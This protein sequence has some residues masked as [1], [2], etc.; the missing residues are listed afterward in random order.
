[1]DINILMDIISH[2]GCCTV[3]ENK[4]NLLQ[5][6]TVCSEEGFFSSTSS[7]SVISPRRQCNF[8]YF[9]QKRDQPGSSFGCLQPDV[10][11]C[12]IVFGRG[13]VV[14]F[15]SVRCRS[16]ACVQSGSVFVCVCP[17]SRPVS[18]FD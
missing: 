7:I 17:V 18:L 12:D 13:E 5:W 11:S 9:H 6:L 8:S 3:Q 4:I 16:P 1:M 2:Y 15:G 14:G 10:T